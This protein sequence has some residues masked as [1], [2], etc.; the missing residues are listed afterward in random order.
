MKK[1]AE[2]AVTLQ[3]TGLNVTGSDVYGTTAPQSIGDFI[4]DK[5]IT[6]AMGI[7]GAVFFALFVY[8]GFM[9]MTAR[10]NTQQAEKAK[11]ILTNT[12]IGLVIVLTAYAITRFI[13]TSLT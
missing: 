11:T 6:P 10:G 2:L 4:G 5:L 9:W 1:L 8:G 7:S 3:D 12:I 13:F